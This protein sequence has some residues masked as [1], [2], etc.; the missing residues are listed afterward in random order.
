MEDIYTNIASTRSYS[1]RPTD[2][3]WKCEAILS[4]DILQRTCRISGIAESGFPFT[5]Q[6]QFVAFVVTISICCCR[7]GDV[8]ARTRGFVNPQ[9]IHSRSSLVSAR[10]DGSAYS[11]SA[12]TGPHRGP[13]FDSWH[14]G[15]CHRQRY[16]CSSKVSYRLRAPMEIIVLDSL[17]LIAPKVTARW[18][19]GG[20]ALI[21]GQVLHISWVLS[22]AP[23][24]RKSGT[25]H[26]RIF[27]A[28]IARNLS[29]DLTYLFNPILFPILIAV[30]ASTCVARKPPQRLLLFLWFGA[31]LALISASMPAA[32][33]LIRA[34]ASK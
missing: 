6:V 18:K 30:F 7:R 22:L 8:P 23:S 15:S 17:L 9:P 2:F 31:F 14:V 4:L 29:A 28:L 25:C 16:A 26:R 20:V 34:T 3:V 33:I 5:E 1:G 13:L 27:V 12:G 10:P 21:I 11:G 19:L 24:V 32:S